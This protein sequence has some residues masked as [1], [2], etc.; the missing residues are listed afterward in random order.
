MIWC[1]HTGSGKTVLALYAIARCLA[2][3]KRF[4]K[5]ELLSTKKILKEYDNEVKKS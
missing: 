5:A 2:V 1:A 4:L 3:G